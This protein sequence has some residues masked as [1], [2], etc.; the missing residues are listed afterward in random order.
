MYPAIVFENGIAYR[1]HSKDMAA[2][3]AAGKLEADRPSAVSVEPES[4]AES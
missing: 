4:P 1:E 3:I 2:R